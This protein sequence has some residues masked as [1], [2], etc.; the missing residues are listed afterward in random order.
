MLSLLSD[1]T[2]SIFL[3]LSDKCD[4]MI[5]FVSSSVKLWIRLKIQSLSDTSIVPYFNVS[6]LLRTDLKLRQKLIVYDHIN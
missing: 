4:Y 3:Y 2:N 1:Q 5:Y 6:Y